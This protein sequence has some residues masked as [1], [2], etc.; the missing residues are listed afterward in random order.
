MKNT[1]LGKDLAEN[2]IAGL[3]AADM[4][5][6]VLGL[7]IEELLYGVGPGK[8]VHDLVVDRAQQEQVSEIVARFVALIGVV[9]TAL[10]TAGLD[11]AD[12]TRERAAFGVNQRQ[13]AAGKGTPVAGDGK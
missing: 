11:V 13:R 8:P 9:A 5:G 12:L 1:W 3:L 2:V 10:G 4:P 6:L 7:D